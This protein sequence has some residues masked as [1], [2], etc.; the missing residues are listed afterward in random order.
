[1]LLFVDRLPLYSWTR[2]TALSEERLLSACLPFLLSEQGHSPTPS[3]WPGRWAVDT[4][5]TGEAYAW[6]HHLV[7]AGLD[8][9]T[10]RNGFESLTPL[11]GNRQE[12][13]LRSADLWLV[14]NIPH[15]QSTPWRIP[16]RHGKAF[17]NRRSLP[18]PQT[19]C[20]LLGMRALERA[21]LKIAIDFAQ[22]SVSVWTPGPW[23]RAVAR[24]LRRFPTGFTTVPTMWDGCR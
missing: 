5:F 8:P 13:P 21:G 10:R 15:L 20:P 6:R 2:R 17:R 22:A 23:Y 18:D 12:F 24:F 9:D 3:T 19:N 1:V 16:L 7:E 14:S 11:G 4:R